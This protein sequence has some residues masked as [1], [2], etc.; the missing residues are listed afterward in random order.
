VLK[1]CP[2]RQMPPAMPVPHDSVEV[3]KRC[4]TPMWRRFW[5]AVQVGSNGYGHLS[6]LSCA[7]LQHGS[8][9]TLT[10]TCAV[11]AAAAAAAVAAA[12]AEAA[13]AP[14]GSPCCCCCC[15][16]SS[17]AL[18]SPLGKLAPPASDDRCCCCCLFCQPPA[19]A[20]APATAAA[21]AAAGA[22]GGL[23]DV[24][25]SSRSIG[26]CCSASCEKG[27]VEARPPAAGVEPLPGSC[28]CWWAASR[29]LRLLASSPQQ[30]QG[31]KEHMNIL[32]V[33]VWVTELPCSHRE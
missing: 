5:H 30:H 31:N 23:G 27:R 13:S 12:A 1:P 28:C 15:C 20:G 4:N 33:G 9:N 17:C 10:L 21:A 29:A 22:A 8:N 7:R 26:S 11:A 6:H 2:V 25:S 14:P 24:R 32:H 18:L 16:S 19:L 3:Q